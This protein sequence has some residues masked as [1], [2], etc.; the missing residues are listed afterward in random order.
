MKCYVTKIF[1]QPFDQLFYSGRTRS[2]SKVPGSS[3]GCLSLGS[4]IPKF[5]GIM[6]ER[7]LSRSHCG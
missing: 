6:K 2:S 4:F 7:V 1:S 5:V 3:G